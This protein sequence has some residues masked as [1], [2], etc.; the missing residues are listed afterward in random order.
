M[1]N[2]AKAKETFGKAVF[3]IAAIICIIVVVAIFAFL[4]IKSVPAF[5]KLGIFDFVLIYA[6]YTRRYNYK[7]DISATTFYFS[8]MICVIVAMCL[9]IYDDVMTKLL[10]GKK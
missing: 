7:P 3:G 8:Q 5:N 9:G 6:V 10:V 4:I 2:K 1:T